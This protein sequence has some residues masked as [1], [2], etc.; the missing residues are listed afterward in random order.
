MK[1][2]TK[3]GDDGT[4][5]L[6]GGKRVLKSDLRVHT[7]G[8]IDELNAIIGLITVKEPNPELNEIMI[9]LNNIL[10]TAGADI[11]TPLNPKPKFSI[12]RIDNN[13]ILYL[14]EKIDQLTS[15]LPELK[16]FI[17]PGGSE[18]S[19]L[20]HLARTVCRRTERYAVEL[21]KE[22]EIGS[23]IIKFINRLSDFLFTASRYSNF[24]SG[25][26]EIIWQGFVR[27]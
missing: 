3:T 17:L 1:I 2:Y 23:Y 19:A 25:K 26:K 7:Y 22:E 24:I 4:T 12:D 20:M 13:H 8:N 6:F 5:G 21:S 14:E 9:N 27:K 18:S 15:Q 16:N 11:A 10:F